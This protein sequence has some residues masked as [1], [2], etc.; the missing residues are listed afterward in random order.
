MSVLVVVEWG[1]ALACTGDLAT[2]V[3]EVIDGRAI[4]GITA[5]D[6]LNDRAS[7]PPVTNGIKLSTSSSLVS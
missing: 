7:I 3:T 4:T 5:V 1:F 6:H 2:G